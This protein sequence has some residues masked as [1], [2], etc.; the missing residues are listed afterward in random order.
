MSNRF[1]VNT[2]TKKSQWEKPT[3]PARA[4]VDDNGPSGLPPSY[5][6]GDKPAPTDTKINPYDDKPTS[7]TAGSSH[8]AED[9]DAKLARQLQAEEDA[10]ARGSY[11]APA[12]AA[13]SYANT[14]PPQAYPSQLPPRPNDLADKGKSLLGKFFGGKKLGSS[15]HGSGGLGGLSGILGGGSHGGH[16]GG[17]GVPAPY[18]GQPGYGAPAQGYGG[19]GPPPGNYGGYPGQQG[20]YPQQPGYGGYPPQHGGFGG[21]GG[22]GSQGR[23]HKSGGMGMGAMAGGA[24]LGVGAGLVGGALVA[25]AINDHDQD[26]YQQGFGKFDAAPAQCADCF[27]C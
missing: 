18:G 5:T 26:V 10:R 22:H 1:Y 25:D 4:P 19:Y 3:E 2:F 27:S 11:G 20:Y 17:G 9:E 14:P 13:A 15:G 16:H 6:P 21:F 12:G 23:P 8:N 24:A 7:G